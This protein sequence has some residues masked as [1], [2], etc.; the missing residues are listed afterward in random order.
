[1]DVWIFP[2]ASPRSLALEAPLKS[3]SEITVTLEDEDGNAAIL[4]TTLRFTTDNCVFGNGKNSEVVA[5]TVESDDDDD[6]DTIAEVTLDCS[7]STATAGTATV[8]ASADRPGRDVYAS[9][10]VTV[11]GPP[12]L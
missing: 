3:E 8:A 5:E 6:G 12:S 7:G 1:M 10:D 9:I 11:V 2:P 4:A